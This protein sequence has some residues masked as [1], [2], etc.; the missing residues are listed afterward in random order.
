MEVI[1]VL[2]GAIVAI[3]DLNDELNELVLIYLIGYPVEL[4]ECR[5]D[6]GHL[7]VAP[8]HLGELKDVEFKS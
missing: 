8:D 5:R 6:E 4:H 2:D 7:H 3:V 1:V